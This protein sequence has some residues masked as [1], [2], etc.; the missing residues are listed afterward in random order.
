MARFYINS[1]ADG[2]R[3]ALA[4]ALLVGRSD[5]CDLVLD[6]GNASRQHARL[7]VRNS[8]V[9]LSDL[10]ST[11]G[12]F[13]GEQRI[14]SEVRLQSGDRIRF[15]INE[16]DFVDN[17]AQQ[18]APG[19]WVFDAKRGQTVQIS[20]EELKKFMEEANKSSTPAL[21]EV[22]E[23]YLV[24]NTGLGAGTAFKLADSAIP[25]V[26]EIGSD[27]G[28]DIVLSDNGISGLHAQIVKE[29]SK[30]KITDV[31]SSNGLQVNGQNA[32]LAYLSNGDR[33]S[34]GVVECIFQLPAASPSA[35][36]QKPEHWNKTATI[37]TTLIA[38]SI[39]LLAIWY[40]F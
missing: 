5:S 10:D 27:E 29:G 8:E 21:V 25:D 32:Q 36:S 16:F 20:P 6:T 22:V 15:D 3:I 38:A 34:L 12:T 19:G 24:V 26:W 2:R 30:W 31:L 13:V 17:E 14:E 39:I 28:R 4:D 18:S 37:G 33:I 11:N 1:V 7:E 9:W 23:P 40:W 35:D